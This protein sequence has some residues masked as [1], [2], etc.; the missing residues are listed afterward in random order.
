M[1]QTDYIKS[2]VKELADNINSITIDARELDKEIKT[3]SNQLGKLKE[4]KDKLSVERYIYRKTIASPSFE[5]SQTKSSQFR[6]HY[7]DSERIHQV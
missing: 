1:T 5:F 3:K 2:I 6:Q 4:K 7:R